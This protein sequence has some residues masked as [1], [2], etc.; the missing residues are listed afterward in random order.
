MWHKLLFHH[1][2][3]KPTPK[4]WAQI[5]GTKLKISALDYRITNYLNLK[6]KNYITAKLFNSLLMTIKLFLILNWPLNYF[7]SLFMAINYFL[8]QIGR[9]TLKMI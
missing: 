3:Y 6:G 5:I 2:F 1:P 8:F 7:K 9:Q 4:S